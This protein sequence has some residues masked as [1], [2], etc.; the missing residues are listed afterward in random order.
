MLRI[1]FTA[2][3]L[4]AALASESEAQQ[5]DTVPVKC[6]KWNW[7]NQCIAT[8]V[9][10]P[11]VP[12]SKVDTVSIVRVDTVKVP[13][14]PQG[15]SPNRKRELSG[16]PFY[17]PRVETLQHYASMVRSGKGLLGVSLYA[18]PMDAVVKWKMAFPDLGLENPNDLAAHI[19]S[20]S[21][22]TC[23]EVVTD[24]AY[25]GRRDREIHLFGWKRQLG[26]TLHPGELCGGNVAMRRIEFEFTSGNI[27]PNLPWEPPAV[28]AP[29][30][31]PRRPGPVTQP[32]EMRSGTKKGF[33]FWR[34]AAVLGGGCLA[35]GAIKNKDWRKPYC[36]VI[37][38]HARAG[39]D[40]Q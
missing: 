38:V 2:V 15:S 1:S 16:L 36:I 14:V 4:L 26:G 34:T 3:A 33:P 18:Q 13:A 32:P 39:Q 37:N 11:P 6:A 27:T 10:R 19:Q 24:V 7:L 17:A 29:P 12:L 20:L 25:V 30:V 21:K 22:I 5:K 31:I 23:P 28:Q 9:A 8:E 35:Y 40:Q